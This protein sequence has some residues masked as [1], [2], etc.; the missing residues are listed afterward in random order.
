[1]VA[2][3]AELIAMSRS[4]ALISSDGG[5]SLGNS[6]QLGLN[7]LNAVN[8]AG[9]MVGNTLNAAVTVPAASAAPATRGPTVL[10]QANTFIQLQTGYSQR[11]A[12]I[13]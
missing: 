7:A 11:P 3:E 6:A 2:A 10:A 8:A 12:G 4:S 1:M 13:P 5:V 9:A